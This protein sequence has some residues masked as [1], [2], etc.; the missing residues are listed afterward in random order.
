VFKKKYISEVT[1]K[2]QFDKIL[3]CSTVPYLIGLVYFISKR[4]EKPRKWIITAKDLKKPFDF[5][6]SRFYRN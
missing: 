1:Y 4:L 2:K 5:L 6:S 3:K